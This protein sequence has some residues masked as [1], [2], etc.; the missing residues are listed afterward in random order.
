[1]KTKQPVSLFAAAILMCTANYA[2]AQAGSL[3]P[4]FGKNGIVATSL[5][6]AS[7]VALQSDGKIVLAGLGIF[8]NGQSDTLIR[9]NTD[10]SLDA[11]F[12]SGGVANFAPTGN[13]AAPNGFFA[14]AIQPNGKI[15]AA[16]VTTTEQ[17]G[18]YS[19][20][21][22][23][24]VESN[25]SLDPS[26]G[27]GGFTT[28]TSIPF[29]PYDV[30]GTQALALAL[31]GNG[32]ILV[33]SSYSNLMARFTSNGQLDGSFGSGGLVNLADQGP[34]TSFAPTQI[35]VAANGK[36]LVASGGVSPTPLVEA[37]T[38]SLYNANGSL[39]STLGSA[40]TVASVASASALLLQTDGKVVVAGSL[41]SK[42][43]LPPASS[44]VGFGVVRYSSSGVIDKSFGKGG[45]AVADFGANAPLSGAFAIAIQSNGELVAGG[46]AAQGPFNLSFDSPFA[47]ARFTS[48]GVL[49]TSFGSGGLVT[50]TLVSGST[51]VYSY[52]NGLAI[53]S[54]GKIVAAGNTLVG[55]GFSAG[56]GAY[57]ARYL[58]Q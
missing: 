16:E 24:R 38:I 33:A 49:D 20:V 34:N 5:R 30:T 14:M 46:A 10:G 32:S 7:A 54:D 21:Q 44:A 35:V 13:T 27:S 48:S 45:V 4:S 40:G 52:V 19:F 12:G 28:T 55:Q 50:T 15:V 29:T 17:G 22:V 6:T 39:D 3:D 53:Q 42:L 26:F 58:A 31:Q 9:L 25:G 1:M 37:G 57:V 18:Y 51:D 23:A 36:I 11:S 47:L 8:N 41:T 56:T 43:N 2:A